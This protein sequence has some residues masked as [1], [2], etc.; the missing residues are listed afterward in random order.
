MYIKGVFLGIVL[1]AVTSSAIWYWTIPKQSSVLEAEIPPEGR[2]LLTREAET[3]QSSSVYRDT[4]RLSAY[5]RDMIVTRVPLHQTLDEFMQMKEKTKSRPEKKKILHAKHNDPK[6]AALVAKRAHGEE[7]MTAT[8]A[9]AVAPL[10][11]TEQKLQ[12][13]MVTVERDKT[14]ISTQESIGQSDDLQ[15]DDSPSVVLSTEEASAE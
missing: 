12:Q 14:S 6:K 2:A 13:Q 3:V 5:E 7:D 8:N 11:Q 4:Q 15:P 1:G 9:I 10:P